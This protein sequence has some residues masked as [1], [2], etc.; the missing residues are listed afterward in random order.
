[1]SDLS[2]TL[3]S[4]VATA[5][6]FQRLNNAIT[7]NLTKFNSNSACLIS[8]LFICTIGFPLATDLEGL[9]RKLG[10]PED[11]EQLRDR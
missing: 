9:V 4:L 6:D 8:L 10:T 1:M 11:S 5:S 3:Y 2:I 7:N